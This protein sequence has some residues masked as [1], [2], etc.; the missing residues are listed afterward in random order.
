MVL[1]NTK[2][3]APLKS[4][5]FH[6]DSLGMQDYQY[7]EYEKLR[8]HPFIG[9][10]SVG[11]FKTHNLKKYIPIS[12]AKTSMKWHLI[13]CSINKQGKTV[14]KSNKIFLTRHTLKYV[15][16]IQGNSHKS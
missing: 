8:A 13:L 9:D 6:G 14:K 1:L 10:G 11:H 2:L 16:L 4:A 12:I 5:F 15:L 7:S 3:I